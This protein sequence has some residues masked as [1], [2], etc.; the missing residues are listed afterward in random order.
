M[1]VSGSDSQAS[2]VHSHFFP[3]AVRDE[4]AGRAQETQKENHS[5]AVESQRTSALE[6]T[7]NIQHTPEAAHAAPSAQEGRQDLQ[8]GAQKKA[9]TMP[10]ADDKPVPIGLTVAGQDEKAR[11]F[12]DSGAVTRSK[13]APVVDVFG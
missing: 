2:F 7:V 3:E 4:N 1:Q 12:D 13:N 5:R 6:D 9:A 8:S 11:F 10:K